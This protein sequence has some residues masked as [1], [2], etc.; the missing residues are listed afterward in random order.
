MHALL[1]I[2]P[3][4]CSRPSPTHTSAGDSWTLTGKSGAVSCGVTAPFFCVL[5]HTRFRLCPQRVCFPVLCKFW[6]LYGGINGDL[7]QEGLYHTQIYCTQSPCLCISPLLTC[8]S[9]GDTQTQFWLS[10]YRVSGSRHTED[11][12]E[13]SESLWWE[14]GLIVNANSPLLPSFCG[15]S[16]ALGLGISPQ[17]HASTAQPPLQ[18]VLSCWSFS[19]SILINFMELSCII[20]FIFSYISLRL[21]L[22][23]KC[24]SLPFFFCNFHF[25]IASV[26]TRFI[27]VLSFDLVF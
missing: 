5:V 16:F 25:S 19:T 12:F 26:S 14:W 23:L 3:Q 24:I 11:L 17:S 18:H 1:Y 15:F 4:L 20:S 13:P 2:V 9:T 22:A 7:L 21:I 10:L 6:W 8:T 27:F